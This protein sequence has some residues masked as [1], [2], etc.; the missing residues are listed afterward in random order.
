[1]NEKAQR[2]WLLELGKALTEIDWGG[3]RAGLVVEPEEQVCSSKAS[4]LV[5][6]HRGHICAIDPG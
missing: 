1:M 4:Y 5:S 6:G 2:V 3:R